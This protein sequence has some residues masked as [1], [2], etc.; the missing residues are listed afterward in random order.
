MAVIE[1]QNFAGGKPIPPADVYADCNFSFSTP[2]TG[3]VPHLLTLNDGDLCEVRGGNGNNCQF[4]EN[5]TLIGLP[6]HLIAY[7]L[8]TGEGTQ[9][10]IDGTPYTV[11]HIV[12]RV[13]GRWNTVTR[14]LD[15]L[16]EP[17]DIDH[18]TEVTL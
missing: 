8:D 9:I 3:D 14:E 18:T 15:L 5:V 2:D 17:R 13:L 7:D 10:V 12:D 4:A 16:A 1:N 6:C 11:P